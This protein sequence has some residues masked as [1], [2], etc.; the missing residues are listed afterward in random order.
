M[1]L[2]ICLS[3]RLSVTRVDRPKTVE[4]RIMKFS[5]YGRLVAPSVLFL[6]SKFYPEILMGWVAPDPSESLKQGRVGKTSHFLAFNV[7]ISKTIGDTAK[8]TI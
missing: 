2:H 8:V 4:A 5:P 1:L 3:V 6:R 7:N